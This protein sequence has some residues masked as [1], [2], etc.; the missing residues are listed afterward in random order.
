MK[1]TGKATAKSH[2][3]VSVC[4]K[5]KRPFKVTGGLVSGR[6]K[7]E[8]ALPIGNPCD[9]ELT[10]LMQCMRANDYDNIPCREFETKYSNCAKL[11]LEGYKVKRDAFLRG[12]RTDGM[13]SEDVINQRFKAL[14][15]KQDKVQF[16]MQCYAL[17]NWGY[18]FQPPN[19]THRITQGHFNVLP[20]ICEVP[21]DLNFPQTGSKTGRQKK[22]P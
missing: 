6:Y 13:Y 1:E 17:K 5:T 8:R 21:S 2:M 3:A 10:N 14:S 22:D 16:T 9:A 15:Q 4:Q 19:L 12:E 7:S 18:D 11:A 20:H